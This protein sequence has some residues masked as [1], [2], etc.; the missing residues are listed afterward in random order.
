MEQWTTPREFRHDRHV[1]RRLDRRDQSGGVFYEFNCSAIAIWLYGQRALP[2][3]EVAYR[4]CA[5]APVAQLDRVRGYEPHI[6][7]P[8]LPQRYAGS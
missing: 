4:L 5:N 1:A 8:S 6:R 2:K 7:F 3:N